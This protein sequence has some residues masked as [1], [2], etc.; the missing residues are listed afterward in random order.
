MYNA[1]HHDMDGYAASF[2]R[3][4][5]SR[6]GRFV[7]GASRRAWSRSNELLA[8]YPLEV[9]TTSRRALYSIESRVSSC[10]D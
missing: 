8:G 6:V 2:A 4:G 9:C 1:T 3:F 10:I 5:A 7:R